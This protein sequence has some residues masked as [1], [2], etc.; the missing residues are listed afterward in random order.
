MWIISKNYGIFYTKAIP[1]IKEFPDGT[2]ALIGDTRLLITPQKIN[3][4][5]AEAI[6]QGLTILEVE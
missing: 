2:Y 5:I 6:E 4:V 3:D 1:C